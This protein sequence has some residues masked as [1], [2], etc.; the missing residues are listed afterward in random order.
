MS[1]GSIPISHIK[2][3]IKSQ[4][5]AALQ[6]LK[7]FIEACP[8]ELWT[9]DDYV[10]PTWLVTYHA[11]FYYRLY[12]HQDLASHQ[13]WPG[14]Q[15]GAQN[16]TLEHDAA[17]IRPYTRDEMLGLVATCLEQMDEAVDQLDITRSDSGFHW[18]RVPK[19]EHQMVNL[20][21]LQHHIAQLQDRM[22]NTSEKGIPWVRSREAS[23]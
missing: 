10:N 1:E 4:Y 11:L 23:T 9:S 8:E 13:H 2:S 20:R 3:A 15:K 12:L 6:M 16:M 17:S 19:L 18:Y 5:Y 21:H 14:H 7:S 22:R